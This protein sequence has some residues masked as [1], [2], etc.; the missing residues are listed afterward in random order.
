[1]TLTATFQIVERIEELIKDLYDECWC[2]Y[3]ELPWSIVC[4]NCYG[5]SELEALL[6]W[7]TGKNIL[8]GD[9][10]EKEE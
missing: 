7:I 10:K 4:G 8:R 6:G 9:M 5:A 2:D 3:E 1:M